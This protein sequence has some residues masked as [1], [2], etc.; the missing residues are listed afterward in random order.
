MKNAPGLRPAVGLAVAALLVGTSAPPAHATT[1][2]PNAVTSVTPVAWVSSAT[3]ATATLRAMPRAYRLALHTQFQTTNYYC[4]P[5]STAMSLSTFGIKVSQDTLARK[6]KTTIRGTGGDN[7]AEVM[8]GYLHPRRYDDRI[9]ADV[10]GRPQIL[11]QRVSYDVGTLRRAPIMQVWMEKLPW[12]QGRLRG[13][14]IGHAIL[15]YGYDQTAGTITVFD[16][17]RPTGGVHTL[18]ARVLAK[19]LQIGAGMHYISRR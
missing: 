8:D 18:P 4:V 11:M 15:A 3:P 1:A 16:P 19:A 12:N 5:A 10:V 14:W 6:M 2:A 17:W 9:V 13:Q 7:A